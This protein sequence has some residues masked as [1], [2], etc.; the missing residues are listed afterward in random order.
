MI[1]KTFV[2]LDDTSTTTTSNP[3]IITNNNLL[4]IQVESA[5]TPN[6]TVYGKT[7]VDATTG[8]VLAVINSATLNV[9][10]SITA[11]GNYFLPV[12]GISQVYVVNGGAAGSVKVFGKLAG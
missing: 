1:N 8:T 9:V 6:I 3:L 4:T 2:F 12:T 5:T 7:D 11:V 10:E